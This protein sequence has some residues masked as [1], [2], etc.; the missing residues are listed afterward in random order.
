MLCGRGRHAGRGVEEKA[1][2]NY[3]DIETKQ[4]QGFVGF[5]GYFEKIIIGCGQPGRKAALL[6]VAAADSDGQWQWWWLLLFLLFVGR[7]VLLVPCRAVPLAPS[8]CHMR[9]CIIQHTQDKQCIRTHK[10]REQEREIYIERE[11]NTY[12]TLLF[13]CQPTNHHTAAQCARKACFSVLL[14]SS[15]PLSLSLYHYHDY[16]VCT[17]VVAVQFSAV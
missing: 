2:K 16:I 6:A 15:W 4:E 8:L 3:H 17:R 7:L 5:V 9:V 10:H 12:T 1:K 13:G 14:P 11:D